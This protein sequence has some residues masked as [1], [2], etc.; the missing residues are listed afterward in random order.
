MVL[1]LEWDIVPT[2]EAAK[3]YQS[4][5]TAMRDFGERRAK[6]VKFFRKPDPNYFTFD[7]FM[8]AMLEEVFVFDALSILLKPKRAAGLKRDSSAQ[9]WTASS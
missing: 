3:A 2:R 8:S 6:A 5:H 7:S 1:G 4:D 9:T